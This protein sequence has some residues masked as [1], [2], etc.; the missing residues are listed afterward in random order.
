MNILTDNRWLT[1]KS[2]TEAWDEFLVG[3][4]TN[5]EKMKTIGR[6]VYALYHNGYS[7]D[8]AA[9]YY[10]ECREIYPD[11]IIDSSIKYYERKFYAGLRKAYEELIVE[12][13]RTLQE[14][15]RG[16]EHGGQKNEIR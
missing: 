14:I 9:F 6:T 11:W 7:A 12:R 4:M 5:E 13:A 2:T 3:G 1:W 8:Y 10:L 15:L 16:D